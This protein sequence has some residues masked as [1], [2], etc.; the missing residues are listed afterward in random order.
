VKTLF[1]GTSDFALP[2]L[3]VTARRTQLH[4][5][6]TQPDRRAGRGQKLTP[7]PVKTA[8][9]ALGLTVYQPDSL[10]DFA[11]ALAGESFDF[12]VLASY[13]KLVP[14]AVLDIPKLGALNVHPSLLPLYRGATPI[15]SALRDGATQ[16]GVT[17]M[18]MDAGLDTGDIVLQER[19]PVLE[20][21]NYGELHDRLARFGAQALSHAID[22]SRGGVFPRMPQRGKATLTRPLRKDDLAIDW[23]WDS[24][25]VVNHIRS[26]SPSPAARGT[27]LETP[28]K[29]LRAEI[30]PWTRP[31]VDPGGVAAM[32]G[33]GVIV[34]CGEGAVNVLEVIA[35]N[36][37]RQTGAAFAAPFLQKAP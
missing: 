8:A 23:E 3:E 17:I 20:T 30:A 11:S 15:Q 12:F 10:K 9:Q 32:I 29:I 34:Q 24:R 35:P 6:V 18:L 4:G 36:R 19:T 2:S 22:A 31:L 33:D 26:L 21:E 16:T 28:L 14:Q 37:G 25:R 5:V 1:F 13:G 7:P 27:I